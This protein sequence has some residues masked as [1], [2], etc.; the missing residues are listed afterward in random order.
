MTLSRCVNRAKAESLQKLRSC[1]ASPVQDRPAII[2]HLIGA[3]GVPGS[4]VGFVIDRLSVTD[5]WRGQFVVAPFEADAQCT[6]LVK[7]GECTAALTDDSDF[8]VFGCPMVSAG[9]SAAS[10]RFL[11]HCWCDVVP[12]H[13]SSS[14]NALGLS[15]RC[16]WTGRAWRNWTNSAG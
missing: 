3:V 2:G 4:L 7:R 11:T 15:G 8:I 5:M 1:L 13:C 12:R 14:R 6:S 16:S 9:G 10:T